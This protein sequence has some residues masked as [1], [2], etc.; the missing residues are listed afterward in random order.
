MGVG[1]FFLRPKYILFDAS[2]GVEW[3]GSSFELGSCV[4]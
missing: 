1:D 3:E 4:G 2:R